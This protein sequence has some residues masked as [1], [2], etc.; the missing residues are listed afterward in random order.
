MID[1]SIIKIENERLRFNYKDYFFFLEDQYYKVCTE[2]LKLLQ[3]NNIII[4]S[5]DPLKEIWKR[6]DFLEL[7]F[8][9]LSS[10]TDYF[11]IYENLFHIQE[12]K[13]E[14]ITEIIRTQENILGI[15]DENVP[16]FLPIF[17]A[18]FMN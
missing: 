13:N 4:D 14:P 5:K 10:I 7:G 2:Y 17:E 8:L 6:N 16:E 11:E 1:N 18:Y 15:I 9:F 3:N 12:N